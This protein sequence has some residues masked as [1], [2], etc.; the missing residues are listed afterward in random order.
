MPRYAVTLIGVP[1]PLVV[2]ATERKLEYAANVDGQPAYDAKGNKLMR[3]VPAIFY[4]INGTECGT[5]AAVQEILGNVRHGDTSLTLWPPVVDLAESV[6]GLLVSKIDVNGGIQKYDGASMD[7]LALL[8][9]NAEILLEKIGY[10]GQRNQIGVW[11][12]IG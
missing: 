12:V 8:T 7:R 3:S 4:E 9:Y 11:T 6:I 5:I 1:A 10:E 2:Q